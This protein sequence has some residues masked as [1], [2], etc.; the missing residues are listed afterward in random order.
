MEIKAY[1]LAGHPMHS[2][3]SV[4]YL[5]LLIAF[6]CWGSTFVVNKYVMVAQPVPVVSC[7]RDVVVTAELFLHG[8]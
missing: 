3:N 6:F 8:V 5:Y 4:V 7:M 1:R 2:K